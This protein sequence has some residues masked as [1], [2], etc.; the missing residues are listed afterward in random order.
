MRKAL[1]LKHLNRLCFIQTF[2]ITL[3]SFDCRILLK[4]ALDSN[5]FASV[6]HKYKGKIHQYFDGYFKS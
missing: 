4:H 1:K 6:M 5:A 2:T 3:D